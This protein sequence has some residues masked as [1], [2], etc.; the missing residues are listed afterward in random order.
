[1]NEATVACFEAILVVYSFLGVYLKSSNG[2]GQWLGGMFGSE[3]AEGVVNGR[4]A[5]KF[6]NMPQA[7]VVGDIR[8]VS[9]I[10]IVKKNTPVSW[11]ENL[12]VSNS[13]S[14]DIVTIIH[15]VFPAISDYLY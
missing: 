5:E 10:E 12:H 1:M 8:Y 11:N 14:Q 4:Y 9:I 6:P 7:T 2:H 3:V 13:S 15:L